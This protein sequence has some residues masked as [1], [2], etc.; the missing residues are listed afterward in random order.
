LRRRILRSS[1]PLLASALLAACHVGHTPRPDVINP[2]SAARADIEGVRNAYAAAIRAGDAER[3]AELFEADAQLSGSRL[4]GSGGREIAGA[5][6]IHDAH[7][8]AHRSGTAALEV[9]LEPESVHV[10][11]T[12][13]FEFGR[14]VERLP[15]AEEGGDVEESFFRARYVIHWRRGPEAS[16]RIRR[17]LLSPTQDPAPTQ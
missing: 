2:D 4:G 8:V 17:L 1:V 15:P 14:L 6:A 11:G 5:G 9:D 7:V 13:A 12:N 3:I 16:W 10:A